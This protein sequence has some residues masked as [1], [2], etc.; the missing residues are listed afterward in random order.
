MNNRK[1]ATPVKD[2]VS[3]TSAISKGCLDNGNT[4]S[5]T[6]VFNLEDDEKK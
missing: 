2:Q 6:G 1:S 3:A 4:C 5:D